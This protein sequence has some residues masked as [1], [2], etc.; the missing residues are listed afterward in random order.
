MCQLKKRRSIQQTFLSQLALSNW[1]EAVEKYPQYTST[2]AIDQFLPLNF[3]KSIPQLFVDFCQRAVR[4]ASGVAS[5][6][7]SNSFNKGIH[8]AC[9]LKGEAAHVGFAELRTNCED[10][11]CCGVALAFSD[12]RQEKNTNQKVKYYQIH[13]MTSTLFIYLFIF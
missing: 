1:E 12:V 4:Q 2:N 10:A 13:Y 7:V 8:V 9:L 5:T 6:P 3:Q 11:A